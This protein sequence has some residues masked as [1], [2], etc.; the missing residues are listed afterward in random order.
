[1][2][3]IF[4]GK[5]KRDCSAH[6]DLFEEAG[7]SVKAGMSL[8][9]YDDYVRRPAYKSQ[10]HTATQ[11]EPV[12]GVVVDQA[13]QSMGYQRPAQRDLTGDRPGGGGNGESGKS[14]NQCG[15]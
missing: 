11:E 4:D 3:G 8:E 12:I 6:P 1:M 2:E 5:R 10:H 9:Y 15:M 13:L 7:V 14:S